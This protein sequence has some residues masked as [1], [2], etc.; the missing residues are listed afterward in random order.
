MTQYNYNPIAQLY[1]PALR[2]ILGYH[3]RHH[4]RLDRL[5]RLA[6]LRPDVFLVLITASHRLDDL[7]AFLWTHS[8]PACY[9]LA[10]HNAYLP[11][12]IGRIAAD[13][14]VGFL[15]EQLVH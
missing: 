6:V 12:H 11:R 7:F 9:D 4:A 1:A 13:I 10:Q 2:S 5:V 3:P 8:S 14:E 15:L